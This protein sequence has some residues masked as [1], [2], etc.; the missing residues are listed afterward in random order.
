V[1]EISTA[2][3]ASLF[4]YAWRLRLADSVVEVRMIRFV[5]LPF[6]FTSGEGRRTDPAK[7]GMIR[8]GKIAVFSEIQKLF[9]IRKPADS[10]V[11]VHT[12][13]FVCFPVIF[14][15]PAVRRAEA[16]RQF[17]GNCRQQL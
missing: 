2:R 11:K 6:D 3:Y 9:S 13:R 8:F 10:T 16:R 4:T 17:P 1:R 5:G 15:G 12:I 7:P 14:A